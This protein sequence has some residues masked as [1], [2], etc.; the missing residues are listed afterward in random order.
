MIPPIVVH[1]AFGG[2]VAVGSLPLIAR[3]VPMNRAYGIRIAKAFECDT[4]WYALNEYGGRLLLVYGLAVVAFGLLARN[5][6]PPAT[7][8][9]TAAFVVGPMLL[10]FPIL[11]HISAVA[12]RL[13]DGRDKNRTLIHL[14]E[15]GQFWHHE[16]EDLRPEERVFRA[17]WEMESEVDNGGFRQYFWNSTGET[18]FAAVSALREIGA[19]KT[20]EIVVRALSVFP[21]GAP[22]RNEEARKSQVDGLSEEADAVLEALD[23]EF[24]AYPDDLTDLLYRYAQ[25]NAKVIRRSGQWARASRVDSP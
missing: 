18:A 22:D 20:S 23:Q 13:P 25:R 14:S 17:V 24:M 10:V 2:L 11:A 8:I 5:L 7:S 15:S 3:A 1:C 6:A 9:W 4:H 21:G 12:S 16:F 19:R